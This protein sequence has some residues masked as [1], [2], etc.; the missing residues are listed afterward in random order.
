[1]TPKW[2]R[3][4]YSDLARVYHK[5]ARGEVRLM[6]KEHSLLERYEEI[7]RLQVEKKF[8]PRN[9]PLPAT[10]VGAVKEVLARLPEDIFA[11]VGQ[12]VRFAFEHP[13]FLSMN[14]PFTDLLPR[15]TQGGGVAREMIVFSHHC[16]SLS[17][18]ALVGLVAREI[19]QSLDGIK[20]G[21]ENGA[22][23][24]RRL[25]SWGF[26]R[27]LSTLRREA[28][29]LFQRPPPALGR[30]SI[31]ETERLLLRPFTTRDAR[32]VCRLAGRREIA[33]TTVSVPHP[34]SEQR[35]RQ[36]I[37]GQAEAFVSGKSAFF[38]VELKRSRRL[39]GAVGLRDIDRGHCQAEMGFW[40]GVESWGK[41]FASEA[42]TA[43][44]RYGFECLKLNR[45]YAHNMVRNP[46]SG[47]VLEKI[48][49]KQEGLLR[50]CVRKW[51]V[52]EDV[53]IWATLRADWSSR[54]FCG[55]RWGE[56]T[57]EPASLR[58]SEAKTARR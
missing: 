17:R 39:I 34:L 4:K 45:I 49:M 35:A 20:P 52:F 28:A 50:Q 30:Q 31:L 53:L 55:V 41:G 37:A 54:R 5:N 47:R 22:T 42:A 33:D 43:A 48:G 6:D 36:W 56:R 10:Y 21:R 27:E 25:R 38:G 40:V 14:I 15:R 12:E 44:M 9:V 18:D 46:A 3:A 32:A 1:M 26:A 23:A 2:S 11:R 16:F 7:E 58:Q 8:W 29:R 19:A 51:G 57:R 13:D 24:G